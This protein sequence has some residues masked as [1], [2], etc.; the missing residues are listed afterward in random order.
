M[1]DMDRVQALV[2]FDLSAALAAQRARSAADNASHGG[3]VATGVCVDCDNAIEAARLQMLP[4]TVRCASCAQEAE[5][6]QR[7]RR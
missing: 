3:A 2:D 4:H 5:Q 7:L 1:D 6:R